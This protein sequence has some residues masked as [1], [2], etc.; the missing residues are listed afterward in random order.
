MEELLY[1]K[2]TGAI[3]KLLFEVR[4]KL[5]AGW[6]E[7]NYHQACIRIFQDNDI[8]YKSK[9]KYP[10]VHR[11][12]QIYLFELDLLLWD[13]IILELKVLQNLKRDRFLPSNEAQIIHY[14]KIS[15]KELG[16]LINFAQSKIGIK[17]MIYQPPVPEFYF[18]IDRIKPYIDQSSRSIMVEIW[19]T[20]KHVAELFGTGFSAL[21]YRQIIEVELSF[22]CLKYES[23]VIVDSFWEGEKIGSCTIPHLLIEEKILLLVRAGEKHGVIYHFTSTNSYLKALGLRIG[24]VINFGRH[25]IQVNGVSA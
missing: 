16:L 20:L 22:R 10:L 6:S 15:G 3:L 21:H 25:S 23:E 2:E 19:R 7:E 18:E 24:L 9:P 17:R 11:G 13:L 8:P 14:L 1:E 12:T 4:N 5:G